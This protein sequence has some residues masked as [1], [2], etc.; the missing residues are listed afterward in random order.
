[1]NHNGGVGAI[2]NFLILSAHLRS[3][4]ILIPHMQNE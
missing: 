3:P 4:D 1:M 2:P